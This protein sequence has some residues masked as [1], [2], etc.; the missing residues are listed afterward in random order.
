MES[1]IYRQI[2][3]D[4]QGEEMYNKFINEHKN[5]KYINYGQYISSSKH[6]G[7]YEVKDN[8]KVE[9]TIQGKTGKDIRLLAGI[10]EENE[11]LLGRDVWFKIVKIN[12]NKI[13]LK[14]V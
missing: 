7:D 1:K 14:E 6:Y 12:D 5:N 11:V 3:F 9:I 10:K 13:W 8:L 4:I 2:G